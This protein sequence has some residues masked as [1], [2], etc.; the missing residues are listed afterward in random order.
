MGSLANTHRDYSSDW[1]TPPARMDW[2][3]ETL[4]REPFDPCPQDWSPDTHPCG[5]TI[6]WRDGTY[7][8]HPGSRGSTKRW[9]SKAHA[10]VVGR[11][12]DLIWCMFN[13]EQLRHMYPTPLSLDGY[14][15]L[16]RERT[17]FIWGGPSNDKRTHGEPCTSP[18]NWTAWWSSVE[19]AKPPFESTVLRTF[20]AHVRGEVIEL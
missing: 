7:I 20:A 8:N 5:L 19:P 14:L 4:G 9:W 6:P 15:V 11:G 17:P 12:I 13:I 3:R 18:G 10:E 2:V 1:W 16:P